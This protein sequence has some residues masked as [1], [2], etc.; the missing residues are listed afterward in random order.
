[1]QKRLLGKEIKALSNQ[2][3]RKFERIVIEKGLDI[4]SSQGMILGFLYRQS[5]IRDVF[6][7][8]IEEEFNIRRSSAT[9]I[10]Q[11]LV[12][13]G[14]IDRVRMAEDARLKKIIL[15]EKG[16]GIHNEILEG[17]KEVENSLVSVFSEGELNQLFHLL[18]KL[19]QSLIEER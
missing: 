5:S 3:R 6:Q 7:K 14:Y 4:S 8:D 15:T 13:N 17:I 19:S 9:N 11:L 12:K 16:I 1:M 2:I 10:L 18:N